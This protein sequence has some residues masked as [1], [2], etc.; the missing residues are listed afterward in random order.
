LEGKKKRE[1]T[2]GPGPQAIHDQET[3]GGPIE[4]ETGIT[5]VRPHRGQIKRAG[6][7]MML[8]GRR[9]KVPRRREEMGKGPFPI[10]K[11]FHRVVEGVPES[12]EK[13]REKSRVR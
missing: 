10:R 13:E 7:I 8:G 9:K 12:T 5:G 6:E 11:R 2:Q 1:K 3:M 4:K